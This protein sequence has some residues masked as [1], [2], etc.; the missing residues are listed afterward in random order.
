[1]IRST[2][3]HRAGSADIEAMSESIGHFLTE[4]KLDAKEAARLC[5]TM[6]ELLRRIARRLGRDTECTLAMGRRMGGVFLQL[7]YPGEA[8]DP[9]AAGREDVGDLWSIRLLAGLG[10]V[11]VWS[12]RSGIN[13]LTLRAQRSTRGGLIGMLAAVLL[14]V[15]LWPVL[16]TLPEAWGDAAERLLR[17]LFDIF[18]GIAGTFVCLTV[19]FSVVTIL[20][21]VGDTA[22][23]AQGGRLMTRR[24]IVLTLLWTALGTAAM[25]ASYDL[26]AGMGEGLALLRGVFPADPVSP[27]LRQ[28]LPQIVVLAAMSGAAL[29]ALGGRAERVREWTEQC[30]LVLGGVT[31]R[32]CRLVPLMVLSALLP[33]LRSRGIV[34]LTELWKPLAVYALVCAALAAVKLL[35]VSLRLKASP[36]RLARR[37]APTFLTALTHASAVAAFGPA[38]DNCETRLGVDHKLVLTGLPVG[39]VLCVP[40]SALCCPAMALYLAKSGGAPVS[41]IWLVLL[42]LAS[43]VLAS[44]MPQLPGGHLL[45]FGVLLAQLGLPAEGMASMAAL[46]VLFDALS[47]AF[48]TGYLQLELLTQADILRLRD[49][50]ALE[51]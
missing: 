34:L 33:A 21:G 48:G 12:F 14:A 15:A 20:G 36:I 49:T 46:G 30:A 7:N 10:M 17:A 24:F 6:E 23:F 42:A 40:F 38:M 39:G 35:A 41:V 16:G 29:L 9:T 37:L 47:A 11:P 26:R 50:G 27:F 19:F 4:Q 1:M 28:S 44:A 31:E 32:L 5:L 8:F 13:Q 25:G 45:C 22:A 18:L 2:E 51:E 43:A 3:H